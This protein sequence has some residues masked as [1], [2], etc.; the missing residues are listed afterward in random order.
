MNM[1]QVGL[2]F[3]AAR[4]EWYVA[5]NVLEG[6]HYVGIFV[7]ADW[8]DGDPV[9]LEPEKNERWEWVDYDNI[10]K[11]SKPGDAW[12]PRELFTHYREQILNSSQPDD[13][14]T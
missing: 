7:V 9:T 3:D 10:L 8:L 12:L 2:G 14:I 4:L 6:K 11:L 1:P 13:D 5:N